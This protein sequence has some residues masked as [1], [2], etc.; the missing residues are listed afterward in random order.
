MFKLK[1]GVKFLSTEYAR[2]LPEKEWKLVPAVRLDHWQW[3]D[4]DFRPE[5]MARLC[6]AQSFLMVRFDVR[7]EVPTVR[8]IHHQDPVYKDSCV[9]FFFQPFPGPGQKY[10]NFEVNAAGA[11]LA[12]F[13]SNRSD[14][15]FLPV[16]DIAGLDIRVGLK[17]EESRESN[18]EVSGSGWFAEYA[19]P[20]G[21]I[22]SFSGVNIIP[23]HVAA[24]NFY[25]CGDET[26]VPHYGVWN[27]LETSEPDFHRPEY[28]GILEFLVP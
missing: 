15:I 21:L 23:G 4:N 12:A 16:D 14:R 9:E 25:K 1:Y 10:F 5:V 6:Y 3:L 20:L 24:G 18:R 17:S 28:F 7:D 22:S 27:P 19:L 26:P 8:F 13:G 11:M 2:R